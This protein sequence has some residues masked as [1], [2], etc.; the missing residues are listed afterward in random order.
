MKNQKIYNRYSSHGGAPALLK[1]LQDFQTSAVVRK[2]L[3][4]R[5]NQAYRYEDLFKGWNM[6]NLC[7]GSRLYSM[8]ESLEDLSLVKGLTLFS[9][10]T[11]G[12]FM[13]NLAV[14]N[15][16][17]ETFNDHK[18]NP[19]KRYYNTNHNTKLNEMM[20]EMAIRNGL[21]NT[22]AV[23]TLDIDATEII[24]WSREGKKNKDGNPGYS[25][26]VCSLGTVIVDVTLRDGNAV[27]ALNKTECMDRCLKLLK[28]Y[29]IKVGAIRM[30]SA[31]YSITVGDYL[32]NNNYRYM[33]GA[34][35]ANRTYRMLQKSN[36]E[37]KKGVFRTSRREIE[38]ETWFFPFHLSKSPLIHNM[39][40]I[41]TKHRFKPSD[42]EPWA[43]KDGHYYRCV[44]TNNISDSLSAQLEYNLRGVFENN[45]KKLKNG[46]G[47]NTV[48]FSKLN[49][50]AVYLIIS[51]M[52]YNNYLAMLRSINKDVKKVKEG[53]Y[54]I[55]FRR[56]FIR[57]QFS[58]END[59]YK[60]MNH[61]KID[62]EKLI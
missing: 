47:W 9:H 51:A 2:H 22:E 24:S 48:P 58:L 18:K 61:P 14:E 7:I 34:R 30:D 8:E 59:Q 19:V 60:Y 37:W 32:K 20:I 43:L 62:Y 28:R 55:I 36:P 31:G 3:G 33:V 1:R 53:M 39:S 40:V 6:T 44:L 11:A 49:Q 13:K 42:E 12:K 46:F 56:I 4:K 57:S 17:I 50:N 16:V 23:Y 5:P 45:F 26:M 41:R 21:L 25:A 38:V 29:N 15:D 10:D 27:A 54:L 52:V 35:A